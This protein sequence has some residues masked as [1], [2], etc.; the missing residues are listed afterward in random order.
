MLFFGCLAVV[1]LFRQTFFTAFCF[2]CIY[3]GFVGG[4][5]FSLFCLRV[6]F[7][8]YAWVSKLFLNIFNCT[9]PLVFYCGFRVA[10]V[11]TYCDGSLLG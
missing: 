6:E 10:V 3:F 7:C 5:D 11:R 9:C 2:V 1:G 4:F 8:V